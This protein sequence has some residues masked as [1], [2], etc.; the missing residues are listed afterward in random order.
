VSIVK[1]TNQKY[2]SVIYAVDTDTAILWRGIPGEAWIGSNLPSPLAFTPNRYAFITPDIGLACVPSVEGIYRTTNGGA[3][4]TSV[5]ASG[6]FNDIVM[7]DSS[8]GYAVGESALIYKTIDGGLSWTSQGG[9]GLGISTTGIN[10]VCCIRGS[11]TAFACG[12]VYSSNGVIL[13]TTNGTT[14]SLQT[15]G[16]NANLGVISAADA[17]YA[18]VGQ[19][20]GVPA[21]EGVYTIN[22]GT[23]WSATTGMGGVI[24]DIAPLGV[25]GYIAVGAYAARVS[26]NGGA[27]WVAST[28]SRFTV[29]GYALAEA[30]TSRVW[31]R[32]TRSIY[33]TADTGATWEEF[34]SPIANH[35]NDAFA[36]G[37]GYVAVGPSL[38]L[39]VG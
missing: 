27:S 12:D 34:S 13:K 5:L 9:A 2:K 28:D 8:V 22:G 35:F 32:T 19:Q 20:S 3:S 17:S 30:S 23:N 1:L 39:E 14:W 7:R 36:L 38:D 29:G 25:R 6:Y 24:R 26:A 21:S 37:V 33:L 31:L 11:D 15:S 10:S 4:W 16:L 18:V